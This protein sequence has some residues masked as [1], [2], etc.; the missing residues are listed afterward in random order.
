[1]DIQ[2]TLARGLAAIFVLSVAAIG[3]YSYAGLYA[4]PMRSGVICARCDRV[5]HNARVSGEIVADKYVAQPYRTVRCLLTHLRDTDVD[6]SRIFVADYSTGRPVPVRRAH[7]VRVPA[8]LLSAEH[9]YGIGDFDYVAFKSHRAAERLAEQ[10]AT[11]P[12]DWTDVRNAEAAATVVAH[13]GH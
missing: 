2:K 6:E 1:M 4:A 5:L 8:D 10:H 13:A 3:V 9:E 7:F 11:A 12:L